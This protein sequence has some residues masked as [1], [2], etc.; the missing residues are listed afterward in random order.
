[1]SRWTVEDEQEGW[2]RIQEEARRLFWWVWAIAFPPWVASVVLILLIEYGDQK[3][4]GWEN[5]VTVVCALYVVFGGLV[6]WFS[7]VIRDPE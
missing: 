5:L 4:E 7:P 2:V 1:M 3:S 6:L